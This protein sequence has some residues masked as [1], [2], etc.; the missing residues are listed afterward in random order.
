[1]NKVFALVSCFFLFSQNLAIAMGEAEGEA[2]EIFDLS[3]FYTKNNP[4]L[5]DI[6]PD[7][8]IHET[9]IVNIKLFASKY[10]GEM[11][12]VK[13]YLA[14]WA[15]I[16]FIYPTK[17]DA[18]MENISTALMV[19]APEAAYKCKDNYVKIKSR[20][21]FSEENSELAL[22]PVVSIYVYDFEDFM[23]YQTLCFLR[24]KE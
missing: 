7:F 6:Y 11:V 13:G 15:G 23:G 5:K 19:A 2:S 10:N 3:D 9:S 4:D 14:K 17:S 8:E 1:M 18:E 12:W 16:L 21:I 20:F 24:D 22:G